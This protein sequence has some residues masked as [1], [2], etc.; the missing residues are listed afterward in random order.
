[1]K[2]L[3][4]KQNI[5]IGLFLA[6]F[7]VF[8]FGYCSYSQNLNWKFQTR[9]RIYATPAISGDVVL[10]GSGDSTFYAIDKPTG[11]LKWSFRTNGSV[12]SSPVIYENHVFFGRA[13][14]TLYALH[15]HTGELLWKFDSQGEKMLDFWDYYL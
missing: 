3:I 6:A 4:I 1:M 15:I 13:D 8:F 10:A 11:E 12:H 2:V 5:L 14:G 7:L 9:G